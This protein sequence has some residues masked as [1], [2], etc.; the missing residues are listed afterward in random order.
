M[1]NSGIT[2]RTLRLYIIFVPFTLNFFA[3]FKEALA[4]QNLCVA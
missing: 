4:N 2:L 3:F 1:L